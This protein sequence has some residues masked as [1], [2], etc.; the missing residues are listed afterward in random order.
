MA[1]VQKNK[2]NMDKLGLKPVEIS[3]AGNRP[4]IADQKVSAVKNTPTVYYYGVQLPSQ[5]IKKLIIDSNKFMP[6]V[7]MCFDDI[8][9]LLQGPGFPADNA[10]FTVIIP[11]NSDYLGQIFLEFKVTK[12]QLSTKRNTSQKRVHFWGIL[13]VEP[14]LTAKYKEY[15]K[16]TSY[17]MIKSI[18][19]DAGLGFQSNIDSSNDSQTW[20]NFGWQTYSFIQDTI[21]KAWNGDSSFIWS[22]VDLYY[23]MNYIDVEK[24]LSQ[25]M[26][27][28]KWFV[29]TMTSTTPD[30]NKRLDANKQVIAQI[31]NDLAL[32]NSNSFFTS[33]DA[34][35]QSTNISVKR[36]YIRNIYFYDKDGNWSS[37]AG[38]YKIYGLDTITTPGNN[39]QSLIL[40]GEPGNNKFYTE[41]KKNYYIGK[42]DTKNMYPDFLWAKMQN[43]EN[44]IDLQKISMQIELPIPNF[45]IRRY[46]KLKVIFVSNVT[47]PN[48]Q[49][50]SSKLT[51]EWLCTGMSFFWDGNSLKQLVNIVKRELGA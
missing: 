6:E 33:E 29:T 25:D 23:N 50:T 3:Y 12:Y 36:G 30:D 20:L 37:K 51:G 48:G 28:I 16:T 40:K 7:Y 32:R 10:K 38:K 13:N 47:G 46:E 24:S 1:L 18:S 34:M 49:S 19:S 15:T 2:P 9:N 21:Q 26:N 4:D 5:S 44:L 41:N 11:S 35:N 17:D 27:E 39:S 31:S 14:L 45:N 42:I 43:S 8:Y 22:F